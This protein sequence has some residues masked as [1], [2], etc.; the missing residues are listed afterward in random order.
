MSDDAR[1][2]RF[3]EYADPALRP[4]YTHFEFVKLLER[5]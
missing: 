5:W 4:R 1:L 3:P 2:E